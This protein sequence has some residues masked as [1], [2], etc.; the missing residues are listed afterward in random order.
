MTTLA[1]IPELR[2]F[3]SFGNFA[4]MKVD[5]AI[6]GNTLR[7]RLLL[8]Q[9]CFVRNCGNKIGCSPQYF[10][11]AARPQ[12]EVDYLRTAIRQEINQLKAAAFMTDMN[13]LGCTITRLP[14]RA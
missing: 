8:N 10:R 1:S 9:H 3:P 13:R 12:A 4:Y 5:D 14:K 6:D 7:D 2:V 11:I